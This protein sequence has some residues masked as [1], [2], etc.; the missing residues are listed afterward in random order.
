MLNNVNNYGPV[1][2]PQKS[3]KD[4]GHQIKIRNF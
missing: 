4:H 3:K 2:Y 1:S